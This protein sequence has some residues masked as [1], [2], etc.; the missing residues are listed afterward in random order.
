MKFVATAPSSLSIPAKVTEI[1]S[2]E[3]FTSTPAWFSALPSDL[4]SYYEGTNAKVQSVVNQAVGVSA[5][6]SSA[7]SAAGAQK[8]GAANS[9]KIVQYL[10]VGAAAGLAGVFAL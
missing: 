7:T 1:G 5:A 10:G 9:D 2:L 3:T 8:T 4:K 6:P